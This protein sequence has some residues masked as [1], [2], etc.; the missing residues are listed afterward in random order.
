M[1]QEIVRRDSIIANHP[2]CVDF[3]NT[4]GTTETFRQSAGMSAIAA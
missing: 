1:I 4:I 2:S 3:C